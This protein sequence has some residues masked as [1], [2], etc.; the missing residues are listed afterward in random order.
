MKLEL[1]DG[2]AMAALLPR[3]VQTCFRLKLYRT[4]QALQKAVQEI[5]WE[6]AGQHD[7]TQRAS[8]DRYQRAQD[9]AYEKVRRRNGR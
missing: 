6:L 3:L 1:L 5:G 2:T 4:G 8:R 7:P 9:R